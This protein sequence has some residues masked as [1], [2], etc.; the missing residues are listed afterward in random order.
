MSVQALSQGSQLSSGRFPP[1]WPVYSP[2]VKL[3]N[4]LEHYAEIM[5]LNVWLSST[6]TSISQDP[7]S[8]KWDVTIVR[9]AQTA[10]GKLLLS[11]PR[12]VATITV[13]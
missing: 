10:D 4:W 11:V 2:S 1:N 3:A 8:G 13:L 9:K 6:I 12:P 7:E 5:E